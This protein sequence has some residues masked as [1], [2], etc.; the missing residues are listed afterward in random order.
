MGKK[1]LIKIIALLLSYTILIVAS[2]TLLHNAY[3]TSSS[4]LAL[5][6]IA[7][8]IR[9]VKLTTVYIKKIKYIVCAI[10]NKDYAF[11]FVEENL[12]DDINSY[13]NLIKKMLEN[14][15]KEIEDNERYYQHILDNISSG[16]IVAN[17][18]N[19]ILK[20]NQAIHNILAITNLSHIGNLSYNYPGLSQ[21]FIDT[22]PNTPQTFTLT[23]EKEE[24]KINILLTLWEHK[25]KTLKVF[26]ISNISSEMEH[27]EMESWNKLS[28]VLTHEIMNSLTPIITI[29]SSLS[30]SKKIKDKDITDGLN[31]IA[32]TSS[33]LV[34]FVNNYR[35]FSRIAAPIMKAIYIR[36]LIDNAIGLYDSTNK[37]IQ[38]KVNI[39]DEELMIFADENQIMQIII[40][41]VKNAVES[42][43]Q[44]SDN[45]SGEVIIDS[46][47]EKNE[48][49]ILQITD[50]GKPIETEVAENIFIPFFT[51]KE[52][53]SGIGL[54]I[55]RQI[56]RL[57]N[58]S[59]SLVQHKGAKS[60]ILRFK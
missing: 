59:I 17:Q 37:N 46:Y 9:I 60:F 24:I 48:D 30:E 19:N 34:K 35:E 52:G 7:L 47:C 57:H 8:G 32:S 38:F 25:G 5:F 22:K 53:G 45:G 54:S 27:K 15:R 6:V 50:T 39:P 13:L 33:S 42:I 36:P 23:T 21:A 44:S 18:S 29:S 16:I 3:Y 4:I 43:N 41:L 28:R 2:I 58:G 10:E 55:S 31:I 51:T 26:T 40:N 49:I 56:M 14:A 12:K 20:S 1:L 11:N